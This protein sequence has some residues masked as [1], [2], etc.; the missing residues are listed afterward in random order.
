M[1]HV[2][3]KKLQVTSNQMQ[4][5]QRRLLK[6]M[7][8]STTKENLGLYLHGDQTLHYMQSQTLAY[9]QTPSS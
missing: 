2:T 9:S 7:A 5:I 1:L 3:S 6:E 8:V 4:I